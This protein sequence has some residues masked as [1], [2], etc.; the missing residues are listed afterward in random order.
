M[1]TLKWLIF[2]GD[3]NRILKFIG[4]YCQSCNWTGDQNVLNF[5]AVLGCNKTIDQG[6]VHIFS[7]SLC[8]VSNLIYRNE[9]YLHLTYF[10]RVRTT[11]EN[12]GI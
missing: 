5:I 2:V 4:I 1:F 10:C 9:H 7:I 12:R 6:N 3:R 8:N 11:L